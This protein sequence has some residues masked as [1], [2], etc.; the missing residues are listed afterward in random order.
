MIHRRNGLTRA[1]IRI[2]NIA[3]NNVMYIY[4]HLFSSFSICSAFLSTI[5]STPAL[6]PSTLLYH[7]AS[8][9]PSTPPHV[10]QGTQFERANCNSS[11]LCK[12][13]IEGFTSKLSFNKHDHI[14]IAKNIVKFNCSSFRPTLS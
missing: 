7:F 6:N 8:A 10:A 9:S 4:I 12:S 5:P 11:S 14:Y 2:K 3:Y 1:L 13:A